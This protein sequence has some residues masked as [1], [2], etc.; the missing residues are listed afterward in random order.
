LSGKDFSPSPLEIADILG[1][2]KTIK[3]IAEAVKMVS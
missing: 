2:E 3:R 1:K